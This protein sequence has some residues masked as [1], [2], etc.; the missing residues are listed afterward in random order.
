MCTVVYIPNN[1]K[2]LFASLRDESPARTRAMAADIYTKGDISFLSPKDP[3]GGGTWIGANNSGNTII[4]LNGGFENHPR[5]DKYLKSRGVIVSELLAIASPIEKW[6]HINMEGIEPFT[7]IIWSNAVLFQLVWDGIKK[8]KI[9]QDK[10]IPHIWSSSTL[11]NA[12]IKKYREEL[13]RQ[14]IAEEPFVSKLSVLNF[15]KTFTNAQ[16]GFIMNRDEKIKTLSY[17]SIEISNNNTTMSYYDLLANT[18]HNRSI[19]FIKAKDPNSD[20]KSMIN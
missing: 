5:K 14:W 7:L 17:T 10:T 4:L 11:Y 18:Y 8:Y 16:N 2:I 6:E 12:A 3:V 15:F 9:I 1:K 20:Q 19:P 13:F